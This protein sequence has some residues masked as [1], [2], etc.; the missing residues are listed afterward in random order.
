MP[1]QAGARLG[2]YEIVSLAGAGGMGDVYRARDT[3]LNRTVAIKVLPPDVLADPGTRARFEREAR[4]ASSLEHPN[5]CALYDV[6]REGEIEYLVMP[7]LDGETLAVRLERG[8]LPIGEALRYAAEIAGALDRAH[9]AGILPRDVK[10]GNVMLVK[11][12]RDVS[13][14]LL[15]FGLAKSGASVRM[16]ANPMAVA[17]ATSPLTGRGTIV[18]TLVYMSP[19]Q[20]EGRDVDS[21]SDIFSFGAML[22]EMVTGRRAFEAD[23]EASLIAAILDREPPSIS[24][25]AP[26]TPPALDRLRSEERRV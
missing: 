10:P 6:G 18:G 11:A 19:E 4:V 26:M 1:L 24:L 2:P 22:Y 8:P 5:I 12:G 3:R 25:A 21:R 13:A 15:D 14:K 17:T 16:D 23:S 9:R 7:F 20:L